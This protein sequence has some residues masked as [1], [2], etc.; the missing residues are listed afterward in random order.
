MLGLFEKDVPGVKVEYEFSNW[1]D[2]WTRLTTQAASG[3]LPD[4]I[5]QDYQ[6][7]TEWVQRGLLAPLD[8]LAA[9]GILDLGD[10]AEGVV[11]GGRVGDRLYGISLGVNSTCMVLDADAFAKAGLALPPDDWT[12]ADL[13]RVA[14]ALSR[15]LGVPAV[16]GNIVH[17][18]IWRS[19]Y[20]GRGLW[21]YAADGKSLGYPESEDALFTGQMKLARRLLAAGAMI[22]YSEIV[23]ARSKSVEDDWI[24]KGRSAVT[25]LW[26]NQVVAVWTA[27]GI[28]TRRFVL[29]PLPRIGPAAGSSNYMK[30]SGFFSITKA[31]R[32]PETAARLLDLFTNSVEANRILL[33]ERGVPVAA[34]VRE[35]VKPLLPVPQQAVFD[36][37]GRVEKN[38]AEV[39]PPDP[40]GNTDL[41]NNV[42]IPQVVD[43]VMYGVL[44]P[45]EGMR[46]L[47]REAARILAE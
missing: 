9:R 27:A 6:Y 2:Y 26:S 19:M 31:A 41:I 18:H 12:W 16:S 10:V 20:L 40:V 11:S 22:P 36:Y 3:N 17:D 37:L 38:A 30:Q 44:A 25:F 23:A 21:A 46:K 1:N 5:Q 15:K 24:V 32:R 39:P 28:D 34:R 13:E 7:L 35:A 14:L 8:D 43:P 42:F 45:E 33:A 4:V 29:R 47:R